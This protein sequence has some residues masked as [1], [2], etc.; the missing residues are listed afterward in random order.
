[1]R[2]S[3]DGL[4]FDV[5]VEGN[6]DGET[7]VL[8]HGFP[9][10][11][12][13][14]DAVWPHLVAA[15]YRVVLP[16]Q[17]GYSPGARPSGRAA[18]RMSALVGDVLALLDQLGVERVH[19]VGHD[20]GGAVAW[21]LAGTHPERLHSL[22]VVS[23]P[24]PRALLTALATSRQALLSWYILFFQLPRVPELA[25]LAFRGRLLH[26][27]LRRSGLG[28]GEARAAVHRMR[29]PGALTAALNWYRAVPLQPLADRRPVQLPTLYVWGAADFALGRAAATGTARQVRGPYTFLEVPAGSHWLP[30]QEPER[31]VAP[32]LR[33][34]RS[35]RPG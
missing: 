30:E 21:T 10:H 20:W 19:L 23:T 13:C 15:S 26:R 18:Y 14:W 9:Q 24:H 17:R 8:L 28:E 2:F 35:A 11:G 31:L 22:T 12:S 6:P 3:V 16:D 5:R 7:V 4:T 33:H 1:M 34:L 29:R 25:L 32:L 27:V